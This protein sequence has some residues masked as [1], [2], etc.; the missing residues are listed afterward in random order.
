[1]SS[2][3]PWVVRLL[4]RFAILVTAIAEVASGDVLYGGFCLVALV[5]TLVPAIRARRIDAGIPLEL[6]LVLLW[7]MV[8]DMTLGNWLGLYQLTWYDKA[9]HLSSSVLIA[10][11]GFLAIYVLHLTHHTR[12]HPV[13]DALAILLV[14]LGI[15]ALW[16][17]AEYGVDRLFARASQGSPGLTAIDDTMFDLMMD[18]LGGILGAVLGPLYIRHSRRSRSIASAFS[19]L[20]A[21][22]GRTTPS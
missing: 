9:L 8:T 13:L 5:L 15:G 6:E 10:L 14:T 4:P 19:G 7:F 20:L 17:I 2:V 21:G 11:L 1:M 16:E 18:G 22:R 12:F 3:R